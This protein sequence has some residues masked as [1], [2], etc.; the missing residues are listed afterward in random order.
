MFSSFGM[1]RMFADVRHGYYAQKML[2]TATAQFVQWQLAALFS[3]TPGD[4][5]T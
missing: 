4:N 5:A 2:P 3:R 1:W